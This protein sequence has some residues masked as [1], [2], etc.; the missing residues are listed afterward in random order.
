MAQQEQRELTRT[1]RDTITAEVLLAVGASPRGLV[2]N[3]LTPVLRLA[4]HRF[5]QIV[6]AFDLDVGRL[7]TR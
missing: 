5:A 2:G 3:V 1:L 7:G 6:A 4:T